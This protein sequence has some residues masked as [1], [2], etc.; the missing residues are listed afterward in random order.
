MASYNNVTGI[1]N[2]DKYITNSQYIINNYNT[3]NYI[4]GVANTVLIYDE[5]TSNYIS[6]LYNTILQEE[7]NTSNYIYNETTTISLEILSVIQEI[8][9][10]DY[11]SS[12]YTDI[13]HNEANTY[14][15]EKIIEL[16]D[17]GLILLYKF[18]ISQWVQFFSKRRSGI[19]LKPN[20]HV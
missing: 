18:Q 16:R 1:H 19:G 11:Y 20:G 9:N 4:S 14:K 6:E 7:H 5:N 15:D 12:N 13:I 8:L 17:E 3:S 10:N 2:T